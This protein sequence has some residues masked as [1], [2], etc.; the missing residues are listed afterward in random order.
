IDGPFKYLSNIWRFDP[1]DGG[2]E[3]HFFIDYEFKS[4]I[5]GALM[6]TMFDRAFRMFSEAFEK[7]ANVIYGAAQGTPDP[8]IA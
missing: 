4:R 7:R 1:A 8:R 2:C 5:L 6:G 3:V